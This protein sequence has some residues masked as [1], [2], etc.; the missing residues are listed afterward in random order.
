M[1]LGDL[2]RGSWNGAS[3]ALG[4][5]PK[6]PCRHNDIVSGFDAIFMMFLW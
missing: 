1:E 5:R 2:L 4:S 3:H 6:E